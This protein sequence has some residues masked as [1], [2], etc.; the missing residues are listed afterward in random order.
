MTAIQW[1]CKITSSDIIEQR[2][3]ISHAPLPSRSYEGHCSLR[4]VQLDEAYK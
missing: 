2:S 4:I 1:E 3:K